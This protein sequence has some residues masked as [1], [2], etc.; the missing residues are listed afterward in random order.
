VFLISAIRTDERKWP[1]FLRD[2]P[3]FRF[4]KGAM[5]YGWRGSTEDRSAYVAELWRL[6]TS[7]TRR[8]RDLR[9]GLERGLRPATPS[10][11]RRIYLFARPE[12]ASLRDHVSAQLR[13]QEFTTFSEAN[14]EAADPADW[15]RRS[16]AL[17]ETIKRCDALALLRADSDTRFVSD[18]MDIG[19]DDRS[20]AQVARGSPLPC[21]VL[22]NS[23]ELLP[24]DVSSQGI[25]RF[26]LKSPNWIADFRAWLDASTP[27]L[28]QKPSGVPPKTVLLAMVADDLYDARQ[29]VL[30]YLEDLGVVI[31]EGDYPLDGA[32]FTAAVN[33]D[34]KRADLFVQLLGRLRSYKP[35][36]LVASE[37]DEAKSFAQLQYEAALRRGIPILQW[38]R[39]DTRPDQLGP[40]NWDRQLLEGPDVRVMG[41]QEFL[42]EIRV[43]INRLGEAQPP[44][45]MNGQ[46]QPVRLFLSYSSKDR[47]RVRPIRDAFAAEGFDVS[48]DQAL[49]T[50]IDYDTWI[51]RQL[52]EAKCVIAFWS[53]SSVTSDKVRHEATLAKQQGTLVQVLL[54]T[55]VADQVPMGLYSPQATNL[56]GWT[57]ETKDD[58]WQKLHREVESK[59]APAEVFRNR[60]EPNI[61]TSR[62]AAAPPHVGEARTPPDRTAGRYGSAVAWTREISRRASTPVTGGI[63]RARRFALGLIQGGALALPHLG[64]ACANALAAALVLAPLA[65]ALWL[66]FELERGSRLLIDRSLGTSLAH[67]QEP[68]AIVFAPVAL[69]VTTGSGP[70]SVGTASYDGTIKLWDLGSRTLLRT[71]KVVPTAGARPSTA[72]PFT[73]AFGP[74]GKIVAMTDFGPALEDETGNLKLDQSATSGSPVQRSGVA[75]GPLGPQVANAIAAP[76]ARARNWFTAGSGSAPFVTLAI[77]AGCRHRR[78]APPVARASRAVLPRSGAEAPGAGRGCAAL[79]RGRA[80]PLPQGLGRSTGGDRGDEARARD[81]QLRRALAHRHQLSR[82][83][84]DG[85]HADCPRGAA[86]WWRHAVAVRYERYLF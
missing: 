62:F 41:L 14:S 34:I 79:R 36:D 86:S 18:L 3:G 21:A 33:A 68:T 1:D 53:A 31:I 65:T 35:D 56:T 16:R 66:Q 24:I 43:A 6:Q 61:A 84:A 8:L 47:D 25:K 83:A 77:P 58:E 42:K 54:E 23:S 57:G 4:H 50:G 37:N 13:E 44:P 82:R 49:P 9:S 72:A 28:Q 74:D 76:Y 29:E 19:V 17:M 48:W 38:R 26:D 59:V 71:V 12:H 64:A 10:R 67:A 15:T 63:Q 40:S 20:R 52:S 75:T 55:L 39:P 69:N 27:A 85:D 2:K 81:R 80:L 46:D 45:R 73:F 60:D 51:R 11:K 32:K 70:P 22:D 30:S 7:L 78:T 5:P